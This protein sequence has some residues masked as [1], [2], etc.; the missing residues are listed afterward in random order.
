M[1]GLTYT[2]IELIE[3]DPKCAI[4]VFYNEDEAEECI[5][6]AYRKRS[7]NTPIQL[8]F[9][10]LGKNNLAFSFTTASGKK[11]SWKT[12]INQNSDT[13]RTLG[14]PLNGPYLPT[15]ER[16]PGTEFAIDVDGT[17]PE[18]KSFDEVLKD[19]EIEDAEIVD[20]KK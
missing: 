8:G 2:V 4:G 19:R 9:D 16:A 18:A 13:Y 17:H 5:L 14:L 12:A 20:D 6:R 11:F 3:D 10:R 1:G 7:G 15:P